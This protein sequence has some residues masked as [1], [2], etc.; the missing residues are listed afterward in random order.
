MSAYVV[1]NVEITD[2]E[3]FAEY[4]KGVLVSLEPFGGRFLAR[5]GRAEALEGAYAVKRIVI[6]EFP[7][8]ER[9]KAWWESPGYR[10][11]L[12]MRQRSART[13]LIVAEG[14]Q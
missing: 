7:D 4:R 12:E 10:P 6:I 14:V 1:A 11:L 9:A 3:T 2:P 5:G 13:D 8:Y